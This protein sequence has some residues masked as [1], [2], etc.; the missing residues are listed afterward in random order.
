M[1]SITKEKRGV[2][3]KDIT[4][5]A[6][7]GALECYKFIEHKGAIE[8]RTILFYT[9]FPARELCLSRSLMSTYAE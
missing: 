5:E 3:I 9:R 1:G 7:S 4:G 2:G 8:Q 6:N